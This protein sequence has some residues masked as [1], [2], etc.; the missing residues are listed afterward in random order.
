MRCYD[1]KVIFRLQVIHDMNDTV[2]QSLNSVTVQYEW[3][4]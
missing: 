1:N 2:D 3:V 4:L